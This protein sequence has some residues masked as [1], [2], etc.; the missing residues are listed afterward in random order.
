MSS[1]GTL[2][3]VFTAFAISVLFVG[4]AEAQ[5][6]QQPDAQQR[7]FGQ[8]PT[9]FEKGLERRAYVYGKN[10][11][12]NPNDGLFNGVFK[13]DPRL[14]LGVEMSPNWALE[15]GYVPLV[16]R[17][18]HRVDER[19]TG[20]TAGAL[21]ANGSS[22]HAAVKYTLPITDRLSTYGKVGVGHS[23]VTSGGGASQTGIYTGA[24]AKLRVN[25]HTTVRG[26]Y[27]SHGG[28]LKSFGNSNSNNIKADVGIRF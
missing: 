9:L 27:G 12:E 26:E 13:T 28:G 17:G 19:D 23:D 16:N 25:E 24:G 14:I 5:F 11:A 4:T 20:D 15:A 22:T 21:G 1:G 8:S 18:F 2:K 3:S 6:E 10:L 7:R